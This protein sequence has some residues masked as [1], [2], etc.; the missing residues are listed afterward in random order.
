MNIVVFFLEFLFNWAIVDKQEHL[1]AISLVVL[2]REIIID[3]IIRKGEW[4]SIDSIAGFSAPWTSTGYDQTVF[5]CFCSSTF[6]YF[7]FDVIDTTII[8]YDFKEELTV[9]KED[10][11]ELFFSAKFDL[12]QYYCIE[13][14]PLGHILDYS[15]K[16]YRKF[17][18]TWDFK[19][20]NI[21]ARITPHGY[22]VEGRISRSELEKLG[23][24]ESFH[25]GIFRADFKS[26]KT[27]DVVWYSWINSKSTTPD[28][29]LPTA[30]GIC[31]LK[32]RQE[33]F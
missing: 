16:Y 18:E 5:K 24:K 31:N 20:V 1:K 15:A 9:A 14:D 13:M 22:I 26:N 25:L 3:G 30:L 8:T 10:R 4:E 17:D 7:Y 27:D 19:Q 29:H 21:A 12:N 23:I 2:D 11:V 6:F 28:F 33:I 32:K